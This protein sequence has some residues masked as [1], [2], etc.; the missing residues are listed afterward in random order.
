[1]DGSPHCGLLHA[2]TLWHSDAV[3]WAPST[4]SIATEPSRAKIQ[5][6]PRLRQK[7]I[8][9]DACM[10]ANSH[11]ILEVAKKTWARYRH[12]APDQTSNDRRS[13]VYMMPALPPKDGVI[14]RQLVDS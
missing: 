8:S 12:R 6:C 13:C 1:M 14:G 11:G 2:A 4:A 5:Q 7:Q 3:E 10:T 9:A